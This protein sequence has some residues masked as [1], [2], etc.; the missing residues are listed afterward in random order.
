MQRFASPLACLLGMMVLAAPAAVAGPL[1]PP[2][3]PAPTP[4][5]EPRVALND[6][7]TPGG[8]SAVYSIT[9][10]GS[11]YL[12]GNLTVPADR[13]GLRILADGVTV[14]LNGFT[15]EGGEL[16]W[17]GVTVGIQSG[18]TIR[19]GAIINPGQDGV[20]ALAAD[21]VR[22]EDVT[23]VGAGENGFRLGAQATLENCHA[24]SCNIDG[25]NAGVSVTITDSTAFS[26]NQGFSTD[27]TGLLEG[28]IGEGNFI[29]DFNLGEGSVA[30]R[31]IARNSQAGGFIFPD[32]GTAYEC[33]SRGT[34]IGFD[35]S[36]PSLLVNCIAQS[37][38]F[39]GFILSSGQIKLIG[40]QVS[41]TAGSG[42]LVETFDPA[43]VHIED[44]SINGVG[45]QGIE[46][47]SATQAVILN[48]TVKDTADIGIS[49][50]RGAVV[51]CTVT[52][53]GTHGIDAASNARIEGNTIDTPGGNGILVGD[54]CSVIGNTI[55]NPP[56]TAVPLGLG[57]GINPTGDD[58]LIDSNHIS[59]DVND[60]AAGI[61]VGPGVR[62][63]VVR[64][65]LSNTFIIFDGDTSGSVIGPIDDLTSPWAN[66]QLP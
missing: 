1:D 40:C 34:L 39:N 22:I 38:G 21:A 18:V 24:R 27:L 19:N 50:S 17:D 33:V 32:G 15:I 61:V 37:T 23:V 25:F 62:N 3:P 64:N 20:D 2:G 43:D 28:C 49:I 55:I 36:G 65:V 12:E 42:I 30:K 13:H 31:C 48:T 10:P 57:W 5:P 14:D 29:N 11:Y 66:F 56:G 46:A 63:T 51:G 41:S 7:N 54:R 35:I 16:S 44:C 9:A 45:F 58:N 26:N 8:S 47:A 53:S 60:T 6:A 52:S 59:R 4:G